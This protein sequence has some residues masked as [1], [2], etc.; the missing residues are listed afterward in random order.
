MLFALCLLLSSS[1]LTSLS[2]IS[3]FQFQG[4]RLLT[5]FIYYIS[6]NFVLLSILLFTICELFYPFKPFTLIVRLSQCL[7]RKLIFIINYFGL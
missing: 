2:P 4:V 1:Q 6:V 3:F 5:D 7:S